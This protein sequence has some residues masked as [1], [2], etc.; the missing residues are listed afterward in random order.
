MSISMDFSVIY[1][2]SFDFVTYVLNASYLIAVPH[3]G[4][5]SKHDMYFLPER[6]ATISVP[7]IM[8]NI[9]PL[10]FLPIYSSML[11]FDGYDNPPIYVPSGGESHDWVKPSFSTCGLTQTTIKRIPLS[12]SLEVETVCKCVLTCCGRCAMLVNGLSTSSADNRLINS[13]TR[14]HQV[15]RWQN[16]RTRLTH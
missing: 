3:A 9:P 10:M 11:S 13:A 5:S 12:D 1:M 7:P 14:I 4:P 15:H 6:L 2:R 8:A 16:Y